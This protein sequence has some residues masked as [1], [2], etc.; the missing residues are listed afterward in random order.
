M[1]KQERNDL[2]YAPYQEGYSQEEIGKFYDLS[3]SQVSTIVLKKERGMPE[4]V[5]ETRGAKS[6]LSEE[7][8]NKLEELL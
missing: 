8:L 4:R 2:I 1:T 7:D 3:Q 5:E 6:R